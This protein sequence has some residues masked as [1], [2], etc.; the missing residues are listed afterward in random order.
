MTHAN[1]HI[2]TRGGAEVIGVS[3]LRKTEGGSVMMDFNTICPWTPRGGRSIAGP[4]SRGTSAHWHAISLWM[5]VSS[6]PVCRASS[7]PDE[8]HSIHEGV[9]ATG[10]SSN[11]VSAPTPTCAWRMG[12]GEWGM[13]PWDLQRVIPKASEGVQHLQD[14]H[15][16]PTRFCTTSLVRCHPTGYLSSWHVHRLPNTA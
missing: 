8:H 12:N 6:F 9:I 2:E 14:M 3:I 4:T 11:R 15:S 16:P 7:P 13:L 1:Q 5:L 10:S